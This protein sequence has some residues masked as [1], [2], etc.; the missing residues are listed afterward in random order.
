MH[1]SVFIEAW[2][3]LWL[4]LWTQAIQGG[5]VRWMDD[6]WTVMGVV[7]RFRYLEL[8]ERK[9]VLRMRLDE[10]EATIQQ[11]RATGQAHEMAN[12]WETA[13]TLWQTAIQ[14]T[15]KAQNEWIRTWRDIALNNH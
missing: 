15:L 4:R 9:E 11:L 1:H 10:A 5:G 2:V 14:T 6:W 13:I 12:A 8:L 3:Q 7:P